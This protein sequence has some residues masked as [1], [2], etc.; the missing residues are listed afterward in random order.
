MAH[1]GIGS[2][3]A[4]AMLFWLAAAGPA[5]ADCV[6]DC[7]AATYCDS[8]MHASGECADKLGACYRSECSR[9]RYGSIAY[10][11]E[12]GAYGWSNDLY[13]APAAE[14]QA[15]ANCKA[16]GD[17]CKTMIDFWNSCGAVAADRSGHVGSAYADTQDGAESRAVDDC[18]SNGGTSCEVQAWSCA[19]P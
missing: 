5:A 14:A 4:V 19:K 17:G 11:A 8:E 9:T 7:Q 3:I 6:S 1:N 15:L 12:S 2:A 16:H 13:D 18:R 10:D